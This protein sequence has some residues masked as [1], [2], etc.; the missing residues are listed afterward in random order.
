M[1]PL[2]YTKVT[3]NLPNDL[4]ETIKEISS[5]TGKTKTDVLQ[6]LLRMGKF[7]QDEKDK[8]QTLLLEDPGTKKMRQV[9]IT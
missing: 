9:V 8:G 1:D 5:S 6:Q 7:F 2:P 3:F 4:F